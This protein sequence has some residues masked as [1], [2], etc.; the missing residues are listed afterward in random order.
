[1]E[2]ERAEGQMPALFVLTRHLIPW[3]RQWQD[4]ARSGDFEIKWISSAAIRADMGSVWREVAQ[5]YVEHYPALKPYLERSPEL[6]RAN[7]GHGDDER[8]RRNVDE[9]TSRQLWEAIPP[10]IADAFELRP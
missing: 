9:I 4:A 3:L 6:S 5:E 8:W 7:Y 2:P 10:D 1:M